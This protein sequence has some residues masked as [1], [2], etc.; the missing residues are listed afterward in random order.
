MKT[1]L[2]KPS[3]NRETLIR[4]E[5]LAREVR[6]GLRLP[7]GRHIR[8]ETPSRPCPMSAGC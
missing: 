5:D 2:V 1:K 6:G 4:L 3:L 8:L 7:D